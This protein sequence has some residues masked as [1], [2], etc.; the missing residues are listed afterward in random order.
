[1]SPSAEAM[2]ANKDVHCGNAMAM[3]ATATGKGKEIHEVVPALVGHNTN[4]VLYLIG[5]QEHVWVDAFDHRGGLVLLWH[6]SV[7]VEV[8]GYSCNHIDSI[9]SLDVRSPRWRFT[10]YYRYPKRSRRRES[11]KMLRMLSGMSTMP[12]VCMGD[13][14]DLLYQ[15]EKRG[16]NLHPN[17][18]LNGFFETISDCGLQDFPFSGNQFTWERSRGS[19]DMVE[20][21]LDRILTTDS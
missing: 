18:F 8:T 16:N 21:K 7:E 15:S 13:Y 4:E 19:P 14:N 9:V 11:W 6:E 2:N 12:W 10:G 20:E 3:H 17:L 1:M 5:V